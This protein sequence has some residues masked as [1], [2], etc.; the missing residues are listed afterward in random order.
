MRDMSETYAEPVLPA[1]AYVPPSQAGGLLGPAEQPRRP[2][3]ACVCVIH[4]S[5]M[6]G[7]L[8]SGFR[9]AI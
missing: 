3:E 7:L 9:D 2:D 4:Y 1:G 6:L 8:E 5:L